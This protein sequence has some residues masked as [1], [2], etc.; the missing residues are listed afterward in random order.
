MLRDRSHKVNSSTGIFFFLVNHHRLKSIYELLMWRTNVFIFINTQSL[1]LSATRLEKE[2]SDWTYQLSV[3]WAGNYEVFS[4]YPSTL[5][6]QNTYKSVRLILVSTAAS[7]SCFFFVVVILRWVLCIAFKIIWPYIFAET[8]FRHPEEAINQIY[9]GFQQRQ[10]LVR[11]WK[12]W[13]M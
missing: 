9:S 6:P 5:N 1:S 12:R 7:A 13:N 2:S 10:K 8:Y 11:A 4:E 3:W